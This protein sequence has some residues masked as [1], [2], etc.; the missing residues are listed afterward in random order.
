MPIFTTPTKLRLTS[1]GIVN[2]DFLTINNTS[3]LTS[4]GIVSNGKTI[5]SEQPTYKT[6]WTTNFSGVI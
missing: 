1:S 6:F 4:G 5:L 3:R 2:L